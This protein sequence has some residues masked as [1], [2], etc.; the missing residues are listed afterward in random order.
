MRTRF[1]ARVPATLRQRSL[2]HGTT[3][4]APRVTF[5][6]F[7]GSLHHAPGRIRT[8][9]ILISWRAAI[10]CPIGAALVH[11]PVSQGHNGSL[12]ART[13]L[14]QQQQINDGR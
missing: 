12:R 2:A 5:H 6:S 9:V 1:W 13:G 11:L 4:R 14:C 8:I 10:V 3:P 7:A